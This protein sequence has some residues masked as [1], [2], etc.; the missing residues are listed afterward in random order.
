MLLALL[1]ILSDATFR[2]YF[3]L[4]LNSAGNSNSV[5][6]SALFYS[7]KSDEELSSVIV[8]YICSFHVQPSW[9]MV[10]M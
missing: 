6:S 3:V 9:E 1:H 4:S 10:T 2:A 7:A 5:M 8:S